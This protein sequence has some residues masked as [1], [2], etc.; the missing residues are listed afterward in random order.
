MAI[1]N[2]YVKLPEG[3][4][5][6]NEAI[7]LL[8]RPCATADDFHLCQGTL[9]FHH[10]PPRALGSGGM[11]SPQVWCSEKVPQSRQKESIQA[12]VSVCF[13]WILKDLKGL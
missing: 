8:M 7:G 2:S 13:T 11:G 1:F 3:T 4:S 9:D 6:S 10:F 12:L 5:F